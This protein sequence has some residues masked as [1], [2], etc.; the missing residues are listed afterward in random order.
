MNLV[1]DEEEIGILECIKEVQ[2]EKG[3]HI[4]DLIK[5]AKTRYGMSRSKVY[6]I[7]GYLEFH[8]LIVSNKSGNR[9]LDETKPY[10]VECRDCGRE[11]S[12][13][14]FVNIDG[15][16]LCEEC[17]MDARQEI[18]FAD[19]MAA[20]SKRLFRNK[21]GF[22]G[23]EGLTEL[24][25]TIYEFIEARGG[26]TARELADQL[27]IPI[28]ETENQLAILRHCELVKGERRKD[29]IYMVPFN[30]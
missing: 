18:R 13:E 15:L 10:F 23:T 11:V 20:R 14:D 1:L 30:P 2:I 24:Q 3:F 6:E 5:K 17:Y 28:K 8:G 22:E 21:A 16:I 4:R 27:G 9:E 19:P 7:V 25:K 26:A 29:E 12:G